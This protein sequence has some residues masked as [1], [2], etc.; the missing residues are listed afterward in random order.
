MGTLSDILATGGFGGD[1]FCRSWVNTTAA[2]EFSPLPPGEYVCHAVKGELK[3]SRMGTP[4]YGLQFQVIAGPGESKLYT[5][6]MVWH[7][8]F[9]TPAA[10]PMAKRDLVKLGIDDPAKLELPLPLGLRCK[11]RLALRKDD[12]GNLTNRVIRFDV[13]GIDIVGI[14]EPTRDEFAPDEHWPPDE[15]PSPD[16]K[17]ASDAF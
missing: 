7:D 5:G 14:D 12:S 13:V 1:D 9:L 15:S 11:V 8:L 16:A 17:G 4:G 2:G 3:N 6:R 10:L